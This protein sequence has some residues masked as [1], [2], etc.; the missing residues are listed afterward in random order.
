MSADNCTQLGPVIRRL[1]SVQLEQLLSM[2]L[3]AC[4]TP[5]CR[6]AQTLGRNRNSPAERR[7]VAVVA[8]G[9]YL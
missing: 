7:R 3:R 4:R 5:P 1:H 9:I 2:L 6:F 8:I